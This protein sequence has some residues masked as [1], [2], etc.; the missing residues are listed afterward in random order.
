ML[1]TFHEKLLAKDI[2]MVPMNHLTDY[3]LVY[4][5]IHTPSQEKD[6]MIATLTNDQPYP[7]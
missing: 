2:N 5:E 7:S 4:R 1:K 6:G 3:M